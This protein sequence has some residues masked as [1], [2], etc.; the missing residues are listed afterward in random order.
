MTRS[1][2]LDAP[3][4]QSIRRLRSTTGLSLEA[5]AKRADVSKSMISKIERGE[6][7]PT[8]NTLGRLAEALDVSLSQ[9]MGLQEKREVVVLREAEQPVFRSIDGS[10]QRRCLSPIFP[11]R[12][13]D[14][15]LNTLAAKSRSDLAVGHKTGV[16]EHL[17]V[18]SG[19][20]RIHLGNSAYELAAGD[21]IYYQADIAHEFENP[22]DDDATFFIVI[23]SSALRK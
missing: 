11:A 22:G 1:P 10:F 6:T 4:A 13:V 14:V 20:L 5:L 15:V 3:I 17:Y 8:A 7:S 16:D 18:T 19:K 9:L 23:D 12:G 21:S 2:N